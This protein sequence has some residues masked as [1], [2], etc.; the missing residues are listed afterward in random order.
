MHVFQPRLHFEQ[1][2][3]QVHQPQR[4]G[5]TEGQRA[6]VGF[7]MFHPVLDGLDLVVGAGVHGGQPFGE[8]HH[9]LPVIMAPVDVINKARGNNGAI[10]RHQQRVTVGFGVAHE[11]HGFQPGGAGHADH[12]DARATEFGRGGRE[13]ARGNVAAATGA[14][15]DDQADRVAAQRAGN[16]SRGHHGDHGGCGGG[17]AALAGEFRKAHG[18]LH[19]YRLGEARS[20]SADPGYRGC[21]RFS[22][23]TRNPSMLCHVKAQ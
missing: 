2:Q 5:M 16:T 18:Y 23:I 6:G 3:R 15:G 14:K 8:V 20:D 10:V 12:I 22:F 13:H 19:G 4:R 1:D 17:G 7:G 9:R 11:V 21:P